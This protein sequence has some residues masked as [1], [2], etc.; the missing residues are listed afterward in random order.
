LP[1]QRPGR[2]KATDFRGSVEGRAVAVEIT[3]STVL[4]QQGERIYEAIPATTRRMGDLGHAPAPDC[5][6]GA[7]ATATRQDSENVQT[8]AAAI[9]AETVATATGQI[10]TTIMDINKQTTTIAAAVEQQNAATAEIALNLQAA[11]AGTSEVCA[12]IN[13]VSKIATESR[14]MAGTL[15]DISSSVSERSQD[16]RGSIEGFLGSIRAG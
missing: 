11:L 15:A 7:V 2:S 3:T 12:T 9:R 4:A 6:T 8:V 16:L 13:G 10:G 14:R 1:L 5:K